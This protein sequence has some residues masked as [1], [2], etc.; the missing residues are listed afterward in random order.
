MNGPRRHT[1]PLAALSAAGLLL[2]LAATALGTISIYSNDMSST[3][4][5]AQILKISGR[6]CARGGAPEALRITIGEKTDE[7]LYR[8]PEIG[9]DLEI[10]ATAR[11]LSGT[12]EKLQQRAFLAVELRAGGGGKYTFAVFPGQSKY[13][14]RKDVPGEKTKFLAVGKRI[15]RIGGINKANK[16]RLQVFNILKT[17]QPDDA[18]VLAF[19]NNK[20]IA[21]LVDDEVGPVKGRFSGFSVGASGGAPGAV[22]SFDDVSVRIPSPF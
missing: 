16:L 5:R 6:D 15:S 22:A 17:K 10:E 8:T 9:R 14:I 13:Q 12:P 18:R 1:I 21:V 4:R 19:V 20:R 11:L 2:A 7:C 3:G